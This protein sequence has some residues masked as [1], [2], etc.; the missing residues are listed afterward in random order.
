MPRK[1]KN[2]K[3]D[4]S[5][6]NTDDSFNPNID[7]SDCKEINIHESSNSIHSFVSNSNFTEKELHFFSRH[8]IDLDKL[9]SRWDW[10][11]KYPDL[12][13]PFYEEVICSNLEREP[14]LKDLTELGMISFRDQIRDNTGITWSQ[15]K[16]IAKGLEYYPFKPSPYEIEFLENYKIDTKR[17]K[18]RWSWIN[19]HPYLL[20]PFFEEV[21]LPFFDHVPLWKEVYETLNIGGFREKLREIGTTYNE[22]VKKAGFIPS[23]ELLFPKLPQMGVSADTFSYNESVFFKKHNVDYPELPSKWEWVDKHPELIGPYFKEVIYPEYGRVPTT[24]ELGNSPYGRLR[25]KLFE[26]GMK[27]NEFIQSLGYIPYDKGKHVVKEEG[28]SELELQFLNNHNI[29]LTRLR[30]KWEWME[31]NPQLI[32]DYFKEVIIPYF[33]R[34][35]LCKEVGDNFGGFMDFLTNLDT[36]CISAMLRAGFKPNPKE[37]SSVVGTKGHQLIGYLL[38]TSFEKLNIKYFYEPYIYSDRKPDGVFV[39]TDSILKYFMS[40]LNFLRKLNMDIAFIEKKKFIAIDYTSNLRY[41][42]LLEKIEKYQHPDV[43]LIIVGLY[44]NFK[45][46]IYNF[47]S[48]PNILK[49]PNN[50]KI[51]SSDVFSKIFKNFKYS[52]KFNKILNLIQ[53]LDILTLEKIEFDKNKLNDTQDLRKYLKE[54]GFM[55]KDIKEFL[56]Y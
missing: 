11:K 18:S 36:T 14:S 23:S 38:S 10:I 3:K 26:K 6:H 46:E 33:G 13:V 41:S 49:Y 35:P 1:N 30:Y 39:I 21:I 55:K 8:N 27:W 7:R 54:K 48:R 17:L 2:K 22:L 42:N 12:I 44:W 34:V 51:I 19:E 31:K 37:L 45:K 15:L 32:I 4:F 47:T 9:E 16:N 52:K 25:D 5:C 29:N 43:I 53:R 20:V 50:V 56:R 24:R 28:F 40:N